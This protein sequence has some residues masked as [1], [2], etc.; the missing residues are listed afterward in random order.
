MK[1]VY[2]RLVL[3][4][5]AGLAATAGQS[6][7]QYAAILNLVAA[8]LTGLATPAE[9]IQKVVMLAPKVVQAAPVLLLVG[10]FSLTGACGAGLPDVKDALKPTESEQDCLKVSAVYHVANVASEYGAAAKFMT[11]SELEELAVKVGP[12]CTL[13]FACPFEQ[14]DAGVSGS[15]SGAE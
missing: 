14:A 5:L 12:K 11:C 8:A 7:P 13:T 4:T 2:F 1:T 10:L 3:G 9:A 15:D 6:F